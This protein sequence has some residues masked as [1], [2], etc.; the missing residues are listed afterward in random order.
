LA[1]REPRK[2]ETS[3]AQRRTGGLAG[4]L[5]SHKKLAW[6]AALA[7]AAAV[8]LWLIPNP[9]QATTRGLIAWDVLTA[10][11][12]IIVFAVARGLTPE[13]MA[14][15]AAEQDEG[16]GLILAVS[17]ASTA[18][19]LVAIWQ[20]LGVARTQAGPVQQALVG[21]AFLTVALSWLFMHLVF[22]A[23]YAHEYYAPDEADSIR[24]GLLFPGADEAK[25]DF[26]DFLH[27]SLVIGVAM[28]TAD[29]Q[30]RSR[31]LRRIVTVHGVLSFLFNTIILAISI[32]FAAGLF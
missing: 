32:N 28:Q 4:M 7:G 1:T 12:A 19:S 5:R 14:A 27:F 13:E 16:R 18:A 2:Q 26:W 11:F 23:H 30:I 25:P 10:S 31:A 29:I 8:A 9:L 21:F 6:A 15:H 24:E 22:A 17:L 20:E 3:M